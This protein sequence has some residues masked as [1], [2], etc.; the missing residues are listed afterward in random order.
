MIICFKVQAKDRLLNDL[1][2]DMNDSV[3]IRCCKHMDYLEWSR[4][5]D[6]ASWDWAMVMMTVQTVTIKMH[7]QK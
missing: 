1:N 3:N 7:G 6:V 2:M 5:H 4:L